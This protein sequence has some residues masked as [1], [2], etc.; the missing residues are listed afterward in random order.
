MLPPPP[1]SLLPE[2]AALDDQPAATALGLRMSPRGGRSPC[3]AQALPMPRLPGSCRSQPC[4][5]PGI[6]K[7][8]SQVFSPRTSCRSAASLTPAHRQPLQNFKPLFWKVTIISPMVF[9]SRAAGGS[10]EG[11]VTGR[12]R[13][14]E[15]TASKPPGFPLLLPV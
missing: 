15:A 7:A 2:T 6:G 14:T 12:N 11:T 3:T 13:S 4:R 1:A 10:E 5:E 9:P 8:V